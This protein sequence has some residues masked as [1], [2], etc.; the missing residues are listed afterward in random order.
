MQNYPWMRA[1]S[2][3]MSPSPA[4]YCWVLDWRKEFFW[5]S[6]H[7]QHPFILGFKGRGSVWRSVAWLFLVI[8]ALLLSENST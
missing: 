4:G 5:N 8:T 3:E 6:Q 7:R 2:A 1:L